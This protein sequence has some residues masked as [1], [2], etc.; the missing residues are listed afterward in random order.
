MYWNSRN[1]KHACVRNWEEGIFE[2]RRHVTKF[3]NFRG[4]PSHRTEFREEINGDPWLRARTFLPRCS[5]VFRQEGRGERFFFFFFFTDVPRHFERPCF[6]ALFDWLCFII[7][8]KGGSF[9]RIILKFANGKLMRSKLFL[10]LVSL[11]HCCVS[12]YLKFLY[13][14]F[15]LLDLFIDK[16]I[17]LLSNVERLASLFVSLCILYVYY[18]YYYYYY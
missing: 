5:L 11:V 8:L 2:K 9:V 7:E 6:H 16:A 17:F 10:R 12:S 15:L 18:C 1:F 4:F 3:M 13:G 14:F